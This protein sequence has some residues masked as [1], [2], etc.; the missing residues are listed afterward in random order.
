MR[1]AYIT[2]L[3]YSEIARVSC[4]TKAFCDDDGSLCAS[5]ATKHLP[6]WYDMSKLTDL[7]FIE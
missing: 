4:Y 3:V 1:E 2:Y 6:P 7:F 5:R